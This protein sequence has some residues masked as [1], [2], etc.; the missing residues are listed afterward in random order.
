VAQFAHA[1]ATGPDPVHNPAMGFDL[2]VPITAFV[3]AGLLALVVRWVFTPSRPRTGRPEHGPGA[4]LGLL[5]P[6]LSSTSRSR[7]LQA[8]NQLAGEGIRCSL[9]RLDLDCY[10]VL[11]LREDLDRARAAVQA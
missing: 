1:V 5:A 6:V 2:S 9:S 3:I 8:K 7:A 4:D 10:D 11:V